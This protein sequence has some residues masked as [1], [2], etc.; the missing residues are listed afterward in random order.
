[1]GRDPAE[2]C[3]RLGDELDHI[4]PL[5]RGGAEYDQANIQLLCREHHRLKTATENAAR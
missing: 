2:R 3:Q 1:M 5:D 4:E